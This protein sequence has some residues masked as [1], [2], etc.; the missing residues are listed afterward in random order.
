MLKIEAVINSAVED[1]FGFK[2]CCGVRSIDQNL[3]IRLTNLG[4]EELKVPSRMEMNTDQGI[5]R[6]DCLMPHGVQSIA[7][8]A[9]VG[10]YCTMDPAKWAGVNELAFF[11]D[12]GTRHTSVIDHSFQGDF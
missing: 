9:M 3:E 5:E 8:G 7:P 11:D 4:A 1:I 10:F 12:Q 6:V 2:T